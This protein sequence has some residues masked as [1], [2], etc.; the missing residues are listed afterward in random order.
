MN[1]NRRE[2]LELGHR[3]AFLEEGMVNESSSSNNFNSNEISIL[4]EMDQ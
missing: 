2:I 1:N 3:R 4:I